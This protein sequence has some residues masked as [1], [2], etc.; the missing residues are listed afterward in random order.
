[1]KMNLS[2]MQQIYS[3]TGYAIKIG[4]L[5]IIHSSILFIERGR[6]FYLTIGKMI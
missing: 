1:M 3:M 6:K 2:V 5:S 4:H